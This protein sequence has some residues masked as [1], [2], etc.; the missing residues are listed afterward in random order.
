[1]VI[2]TAVWVLVDQ[3]SK[4]EVH[5]YQVS[6]CTREIWCVF[7]VQIVTYYDIHST[8]NIFEDVVAYYS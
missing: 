5:S 7:T 4:Y 6:G 3:L 1:M 8:L 2:I